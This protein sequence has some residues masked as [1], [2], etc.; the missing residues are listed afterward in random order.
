VVDLSGRIDIV[1]EDGTVTAIGF[2]EAVEV[3]G[4]D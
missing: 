3:R 2:G 1:D 4:A